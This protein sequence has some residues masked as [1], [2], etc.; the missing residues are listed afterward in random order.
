M[1]ISVLILTYNEEAA[2]PGC[3]D[4]VDWCDD[5]LVFDSHSTDRTCAIASEHGARVVLRRFDDFASQRNAGLAEAFKHAWVLMLD[6]D[7]RVP[8]DLAREM[9]DAVAAAADDVGAFRMRRKDMWGARWLRRS[10]G[11]PTWFTRLV[12]AG[13]VKVSRPVNESYD[14]EGRC[15]VLESHL[16]HYPFLKGLSWWIARHDRYSSSEADIAR[17]ERREPVRMAS[18]LGRDPLIRRRTLKLLGHRLPARPLMVFA[19]LYV[20]RGGFLDGIPGLRYILLR[21]WYELMIDIKMGEE[22]TR[23]HSSH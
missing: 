19:Y 1:T 11:Y 22:S 16:L 2:L 15:G 4:S 9:T 21:A 17:A 18:L 3:L 23:A 20:L 5:V 7:E 12:R 13:H 10:S 6:A 14:V 8:S